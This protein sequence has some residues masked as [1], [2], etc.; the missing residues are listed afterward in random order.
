M[1]HPDLAGGWAAHAR[2]HCVWIVSPPGYAHS[3]TFAELALALSAA[4]AEA[5]GD[6]PVL[7]QPDFGGRLPIVLGAN[8]LPRHPPVALPPGTLLYNLEQAASGWLQPGYVA[9]LER[10]AVLDFSQANAARLR[11]RG[12][13]V[14]AV[15]EPGYTAAMTRLAPRR[16][17]CDVLFYG[18]LNERRRHLLE[19]LRSAGL[20]VRHLFGV[21]GPRRDAA[22][23]GAR[24]VLNLHFY[25]E[26]AFE[27][28]RVA[29]LLANAIPVVSEGDPADPEVGELAA[30][31]ALAPYE[32]LVERC[33]ALCR[34]DAARLALGRRGLAL[35]RQ[36]SQAQGLRRLFGEAG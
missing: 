27:I 4:F 18:S 17:E 35:F 11:A 22:I 10:H 31:L 26:A 32:G 5:G 30:G 20:A 36:R 6:A 9:W 13:A 21:Y 12:V 34:D 2:R 8:L 25:E 19:E 24:L 33:V 7:R 29:W 3:E 15:L 1:T 28:V 23:E 14:A 16:P